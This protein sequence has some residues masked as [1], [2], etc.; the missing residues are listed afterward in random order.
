MPHPLGADEQVGR[1]DAAGIV[2]GVTDFLPFGDGAVVKLPGEDVSVNLSAFS[3]PHADHSVTLGG[4]SAGPQPTIGGLENSLPETFFQRFPRSASTSATTIVSIPFSNGARLG[5]ER[6]V[7]S[8]AN[9]INEG[10][11][12]A[13]SWHG[14]TPMKA[15]EIT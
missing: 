15:I 12:G 7:A 2:A 3:P 6:L 1:I 8:F 14:T 5:F 9:A 11:I 13:V 10:P 4:G